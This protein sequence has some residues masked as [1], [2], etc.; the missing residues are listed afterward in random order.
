MRR[1]DG[2]EIWVEDHGHYVHDKDGNIIYHEG[3]LRDITERKQF[4]KSLLA[5]NRHALQLNSATNMEE[6]IE[7]TLDAMQLAFGFDFGDVLIVEDGSL[8]IKGSRGMEAT[9]H[10]YHW[11]EEDW[12]FWQRIR[13]R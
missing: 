5:L 10:S 3:I 7:Y 13:N 9:Y 2:S 4:E 11:M 1:K 8:R 6:I 12:S